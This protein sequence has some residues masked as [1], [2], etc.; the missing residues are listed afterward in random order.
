MLGIGNGVVYPNKQM[1]PVG[2]QFDRDSSQYINVGDDNSLSFG[3]GSADVAM[4][5]SMW[6]NVDLS[7]SGNVGLIVK[8]EEYGI[9][10]NNQYNRITFLRE[11]KSASGFIRRLS[12]TNSIPDNEWVHIVCTS[13]DSETQEGM[14]IY[15]NNVEYSWTVGGTSYTAVENTSND[16]QIG[17]AVNSAI[18]QSGVDYVYTTGIIS[19]VA[20]WNSELSAGNV[21][22]LFN[23]GREYDIASGLGT[24]LVAW[25]PLNEG[26][27]T[28]A[29]DGS[30]NSNTG[31]LTNGP[32][33]YTE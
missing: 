13:D 10:I 6:V 21:T 25:W 9:F 20:M 23:G 22:T 3:T 4:S 31:T 15:I 19:N 11:D 8:G 16:L 7:V 29:A 17:R 14:S 32:T 24:N 18:D 28:S 12:N 2:V 27:G 5:I 30:S 1:H 26:T 33:W